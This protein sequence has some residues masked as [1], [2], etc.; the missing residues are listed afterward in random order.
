MARAYSLDLRQKV[1][2]FV[3]Q[4]ESKEEAAR[5][6]NIGI[7]SVYRWLR[8]YNKTGSLKPKKRVFLP[9]KVNV[10]SLRAYVA[11]NPD[12]TLTEI[13]NALALGAQTVW[14]YLKRLKITR[15]KKRPVMR[16]VAQK[17]EQNF[18]KH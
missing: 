3:L 18:K 15:K 1:V 16:K 4:G 10:E 13:G 6:F 8:L 12:H 14:K 5:V 7:D 11:K 2:E 9:K 17:N